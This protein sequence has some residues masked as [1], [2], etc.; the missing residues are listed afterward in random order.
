MWAQI[1]DYPPPAGAGASRLRSEHRLQVETG[2]A[3]SDP[4]G[5]NG[6]DVTLAQ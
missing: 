1:R 6:V 3:L 5:G 4:L 2:N